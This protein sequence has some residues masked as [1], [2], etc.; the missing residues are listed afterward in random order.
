MNIKRLKQ[1]RINNQIFTITWNSKHDGGDFNY[2]NKSIHI[3]TKN[4]ERVFEILSHE[5]FE[6]AA[7]EMHVRFCRND[8]PQDHIFMYDHR[9]HDTMIGMFTGWLGQFL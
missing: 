3:G 1:I 8:C 9:Q 6:I 4:Q 5:L 2:A 7:I